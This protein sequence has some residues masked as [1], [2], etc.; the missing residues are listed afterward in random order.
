M[1]PAKSKSKSNDQPALEEDIA[2]LEAEVGRVVA[3]PATSDA[4]RVDLLS[5]MRRLKEKAR[6]R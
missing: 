4:K 5:R 6:S 1:K 3:L 2:S